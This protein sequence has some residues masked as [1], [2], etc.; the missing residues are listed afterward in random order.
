MERAQQPGEGRG[1]TFAKSG[2]DLGTKLLGSGIGKE[3]INKT[4][5]NIPNIFKFGVSKIKNK[6]VQQAM[7]SDIA[8]M[9]V[10]EAQ[11]KAKNK[12]TS[13]FDEYKKFFCKF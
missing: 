3:I 12:Y 6:N 2:I 11:N 13:L 5:D 4:I 7:A 8:N 1:S 10:E 9:V